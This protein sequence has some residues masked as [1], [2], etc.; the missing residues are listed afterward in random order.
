MNRSTLEEKIM[1]RALRFAASFVLVLSLAGTTSAA[2]VI[3]DGD[4]ADGLWS[5]TDNWRTNALPTDADDAIVNTEPGP[6]IDATVTA[7]ALDVILGNA[8]GETGRITM[9]GGTLTVHKTGS[10][11]PGLWIG[12]R[13]IGYLDMSGGEIVADNVYLPRNVPGQGYM[14]MSDGSVTAGNTFTLGL[15]GGE[16]GE[17]TMTGGAVHVAKMFRCADIG[18]ALIIANAIAISEGK[19]TKQQAVDVLTDLQALLADPIPYALFRRHVY[20]KIEQYPGLY[21]ISEIYFA[22]LAGR[23]MMFKADREMLIDWIGD[24]IRALK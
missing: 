15:H 21:E 4:G 2:D 5:T 23:Q 7:D 13:G 24:R 16:Y 8:D 1:C 14:T 10:G 17:F 22:E 12:N 20:K 6:V 9:T 19:Y 11:G 18:N 3:W